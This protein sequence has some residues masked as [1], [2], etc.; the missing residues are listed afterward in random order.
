[1]VHLHR[2]NRFSG[3]IAELERAAAGGGRHLPAVEQHQIEIGADAAHGHARTFAGVAVDRHAADALQRLGQIGVGELADILGDDAVDDALGVALEV[4]RRGQAAF[5]AGD[6]DGVERS[7]VVAG[8]GPALLSRLRRSLG[9]GV[10]AGLGRRCGAL[11]IRRLAQGQQQCGRQHS[12]LGGAARLLHRNSS[13]G[14][15][16]ARAGRSRPA[17]LVAAGR[18]DAR[19]TA[20]SII[21]T[22]VL[23]ASR[24]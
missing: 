1:L 6:D 17:P 11:R 20:L 10:G 16:D 15:H 7:G 23:P 22:K 5:D 21:W 2:G 4:H 3:Q 14:F 19:M 12:A 9:L 18:F 24:R 8:A 13:P